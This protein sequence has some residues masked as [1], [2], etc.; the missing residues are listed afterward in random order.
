M[1]S[2]LSKPLAAWTAR[3]IRMWSRNALVMQQRVF[4]QL[5]V[6]GRTTLFGKDHWLSSVKT[7]EEYR[8]QVPVRDYEGLKPYIEKIKAGEENILWPGRPLYLSKTSGT[9]SGIKYIPI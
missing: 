1:L 6:G 9:T 3:E 2:V 4:E 8:E 7:Y 5:L